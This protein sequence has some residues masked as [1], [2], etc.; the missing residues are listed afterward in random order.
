[1][2]LATVVRAQPAVWLLPALLVLGAIYVANYQAGTSD[3]Y[4]LAFA[5]AGQVV[6][7][8]VAPIVAGL[9]A[10]EA[11]R[12]RTSGVWGGPHVRSHVAIAADALW[13]VIAVG[14]TVV[15]ACMA[16]KMAV[17]GT[18]PIP[19]A[20]LITL[21]VLVIAAHSV[22]GFA[23]GL[24]LAAVVAVPAALMVSF[25]WMAF[26][27]ALE[28]VWIRHLTGSVMC[29]RLQDQLAPEALA[30]AASVALGLLLA[31]GL[32]ASQRTP[33]RSAV[34]AIV[35]LSIGGAVG[36][37]F[38]NGL[39]PYAVKPRDGTEL[40]C[41]SDQQVRVCVW[42]EHTSRLERLTGLAKEASMAWE[43]A[44]LVTQTFSEDA[45]DPARG[46]LDFTLTAN[47]EDLLVSLALS[48]LPT[49]PA[50]AET[51]PYP[52]YDA[53]DPTLAWLV[54]LAGMSDD[55]LRQRFGEASDP[56]QPAPVD[57]VAALAAADEAT[58]RAWLARN[59]EAIRSCDI[60]PASTPS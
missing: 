34:S 55:G 25:L 26:P 37:I 19:D 29:C 27:R 44:G 12:L 20:A 6:I 52:G 1:M 56:D 11:R 45:S 3:P 54:S 36:A 17:G 28:P 47:D 48:A 13:P 35:A 57:V 60:Q 42:P 31:G 16:F 32:L 23:L 40:T 58:Q 21:V 10:W 30:G 46:R 22:A 49:F 2:R 33:G 9:G 24:R 50:C 39:G 41:R 59:I 7:G 43:R 4:A 8:F 14:A 38:V 5:A 51:A 18:A 15:V 53:V